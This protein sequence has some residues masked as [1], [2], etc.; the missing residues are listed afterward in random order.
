VHPLLAL[1]PAKDSIDLKTQVR[2]VGLQTT[3]ETFWTGITA[4]HDL[5]LA[6][7]WLLISTVPALVVRCE[8]EFLFSLISR[9]MYASSGQETHSSALALI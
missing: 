5:Y 1:E 4:A 8:I 7:F 2:L 3:S 6:L 9:R